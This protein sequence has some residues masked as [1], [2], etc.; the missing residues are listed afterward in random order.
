MGIATNNLMISG[1][2]PLPE[3]VLV[4]VDL[5]SAPPI[6]C[7]AT[8]KLSWPENGGHTVLLQ[9]FALDGN[10]RMAWSEL[11]RDTRH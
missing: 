7:W 3:N 2:A 11:V 5:G 8:A 1:P 9:P 6:T 4:Q 10:A